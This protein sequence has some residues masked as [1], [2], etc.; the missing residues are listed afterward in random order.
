MV[1][2]KINGKRAQKLIE[3]GAK[4]YDVRSPIAF[5]DGTLPGALNLSLRQV[6]TLISLPKTTKLIFFGDSNEDEN[7]K[8]I[9]NYVIQFGF[10]DVYCL[11]SKDN[12]DQ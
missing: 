10:I 4:L 6:S 11:G 2:Q 9:M 8:C 3:K 7:L 12:W 5:R 1:G